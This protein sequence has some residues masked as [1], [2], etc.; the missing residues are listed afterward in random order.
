MHTDIYKFA[1]C[2]SSKFLET[3]LDTFSKKLVSQNT[4]SKKECSNHRGNGVKRNVRKIIIFHSTAS[5]Y[6]KI[7]V[8]SSSVV[9]NARL[10]MFCT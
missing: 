9:I 8:L 10:K 6:L 5:I 1:Q 4:K 7:P 3:K 2:T